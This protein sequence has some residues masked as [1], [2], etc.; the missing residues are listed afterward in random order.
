MVR[1]SNKLIAEIL[2]PANL[3]VQDENDY[4]NEHLALLK[5]PSSNVAIPDWQKQPS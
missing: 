3:S 1:L 5:N 4:E 2:K